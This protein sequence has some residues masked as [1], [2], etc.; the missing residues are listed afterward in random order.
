M[1]RLRHAYII[2]T[3]VHQFKGKFEG[4]YMGEYFVLRRAECVV[5]AALPG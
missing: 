5:C 3:F 4:G 2:C 1:A